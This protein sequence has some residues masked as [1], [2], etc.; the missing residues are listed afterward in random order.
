MDKSFAIL[1]IN[2]CIKSEEINSILNSIPNKSEVLTLSPYSHYLAQN[3]TGCKLITFHDLI[4]VIDFKE[5]TLD[6]YHKITSKA[7]RYRHYFFLLRE[8]MTLR[9]YQKYVEVIEEECRKKK[10]DGYR[11][12]YITDTEQGSSS[13]REIFNNTCSLLHR[14]KYID[15]V[16]VHKQRA[17]LFYTINA[18]VDLVNKVRYKKNRVKT[19]INK[20]LDR[21]I[22]Y[23]GIYCSHLYKK[24]NL[25]SFYFFLKI[26]FKPVSLKTF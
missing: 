22:G 18:L 4:S 25:D 13:P 14:I 10:K 17:D 20:M 21:R 2:M 24:T 26:I 3:L 1:D 15:E 23:D 16:H 11:V 7:A 19:L 8:I 12:L 9:T 6:T 5:C